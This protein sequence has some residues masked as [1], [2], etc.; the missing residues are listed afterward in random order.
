M[1]VSKSAAQIDA[2]ALAE[3]WFALAK[4]R[5]LRGLARSMAVGKGR[6]HATRIVMERLPERY[7][8][9]QQA[10]VS[11]LASPHS[12]VRFECAHALDQFGDEATRPALARLM[13]DQVPRVRWM[14][15]H[16]LSCHACG[17]KP[18][19]LETTVRERIIDATAND[20]SPRVRRHAAVALGLAYELR[21]APVLE[22]EARERGHRQG[23]EMA[24]RAR[25][26]H[27]RPDKAAPTGL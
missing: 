5:D 23:A 9:F 7:V 12:R 24:A 22:G 10:L 3:R 15:M 25:G 18:D 20:P 17:E 8:T 26:E 19:T 16:A 4:A 6:L 13:D 27:A 11:G 14:A 1:P 21:A 2:E